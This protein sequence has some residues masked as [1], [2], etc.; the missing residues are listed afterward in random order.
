[1]IKPIIFPN[2]K[3]SAQDH[4]AIFAAALPDGILAG[5]AITYTG[6]TLNIGTGRLLVGGREIQIISTESIS[7]GLTSAVARV[8]AKI[9]TSQLSTAD[10]FAQF[11]WAVDY[12]A[13]VAALPA[14]QQGDINGIGTIY[15]AE[16]CVLSTSA[17]GITGI[18]RKI[19]A[20]G[21]QGGKLFLPYNNAN[22]IGSTLPAA[23]TAGRI[24]LKL[25]KV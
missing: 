20:T 16:I 17:S 4:G 1:M 2:K 6:A 24:F 23:G 8:K 19:G 25:K 15:E 14:L 7:V 13:S 9:D 11:S 18:T 5:C 3:V 10:T 22:L 12:A 21:F